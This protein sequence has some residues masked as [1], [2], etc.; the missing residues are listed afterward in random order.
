MNNMLWLLW[1]VLCV[2]GVGG[3][4]LITPHPILVSL[5]DTPMSPRPS[6]RSQLRAA[7]TDLRGTSILQTSMQI[8]TN[9]NSIKYSNTEERDKRRLMRLMFGRDGP[10]QDKVVV[11]VKMIRDSAFAF[12]HGLPVLLHNTTDLMSP[13]GVVTVLVVHPTTARVLR[14]YHH[15]ALAHARPLHA[16]IDSLQPG[17]LLVI[18]G[19]VVWLDP[20][21]RLFLN[22]LGNTI[23]SGAS[24]SNVVW[25]WVG[26]VNGGTLGQVGDNPWCGGLSHPPREESGRWA[27]RA[28]LCQDYDGY[29]TW[30]SCPPPPPPA[31]QLHHSSTTTMLWEGRGAL[32]DAVTI[33][34]ASRPDALHRLLLSVRAA[35][36]PSS[37]INVFV[38]ESHGVQLE[39][40]DRS[41]DCEGLH[42][43]RLYESSIM[44]TLIL[45]PKHQFF[46]ILEDD[47]EVLPTFY[48]WMARGRR[49]L[50]TSQEYVCVNSLRHDQPYALYSYH[51]PATALNQHNH[52]SGVL[53]QQVLSHLNH[54]AEGEGGGIWR[55]GSY[56]PQ[57]SREEDDVL[58]KKYPNL[59]E[60]KA[61]DVREAV[62]EEGERSGWRFMAG[63]GAERPVVEAMIRF[64]PLATRDVDWQHLLDFWAGLSPCLTPARPHSRHAQGSTYALGDDLPPLT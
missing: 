8:C 7:A 53:P 30:C 60:K 29:G 31:P 32:K 25:A 35:G 21:V 43:T 1:W 9:N 18:A 28:E 38:C 16:F 11:L 4:R 46:I 34:L 57:V 52:T 14:T 63:W 47:M 6:L 23:P 37:S 50:H 44:T 51:L 59:Q 22:Q 61:E 48:R 33:V 62:R 41:S 13:M 42:V 2:G 40:T 5:R 64:W 17:R 12:I 15:P 39:E 27:A 45:R 56:H 58:V 19:L 26:V 24:R 20:S 3:G 36:A 49:L 54:T 55:S 10:P